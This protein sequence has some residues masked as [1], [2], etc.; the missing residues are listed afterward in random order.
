ML[1]NKVYMI[2]CVWNLLR[3]TLW[4]YLSSERLRIFCQIWRREHW[5]AGRTRAMRGLEGCTEKLGPFRETL[6]G[7][8]RFVETPLHDI[9]I[10]S[11]GSWSRLVGPLLMT[12]ALIGSKDW[13][14]YLSLT[15]SFPSACK[16]EMEVKLQSQ[17]VSRAGFISGDTRHLSKKVP[18]WVW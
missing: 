13:G 3:L 16:C 1:E 18:M 10:S 15:C 14:L 2:T 5:E 17:P 11:S 6:S 4:L 9:F 12:S 7:F 8:R